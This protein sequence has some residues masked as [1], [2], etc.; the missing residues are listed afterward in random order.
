M[1]GAGKSTLGKQLA[2]KMLLPF[3]DL[4]KEIEHQEGMTI[5]EIFREHGEEYFRE[6]EARKLRA[7][8]QR[9]H[10][11]IMATG[12][13]SPCFYQSI[14]FMKEQGIVLFMD[15]DID[16]IYDRVKKSS[17][18][19]LLSLETDEELKDRL[20]SLRSK[21]LSFYEQADLTF[22]GSSLLPEAVAYSL[23]LFKKENQV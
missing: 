16:A 11:F 15:V 6:I 17:D 9:Q 19:P 22:T 1:P 13:G 3:V 21:R 4:D 2:E 20:E 23:M 18:R 14:A 12:G 10:S 7:V 5:Q 8:S